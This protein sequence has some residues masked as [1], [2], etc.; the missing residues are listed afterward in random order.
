MLSIS[1]TKSRSYLNELL[2]SLN[3]STNPDSSSSV[4]SDVIDTDSLSSFRSNEETV[5]AVTANSREVFLTMSVF[6]RLV[7]PVVLFFLLFASHSHAGQ[8][9]LMWDPP[10]I[11][12]D[13]TGYVVDYGTAS[14]SYTQGINVGNTTSYTVGNLSDGQTYYFV[15]AAYNS[16]GAESEYSNEV[17]KAMDIAQSPVLT[18]NKTGTG[19]GVVSGNGISCGSICSSSYNTG[20][21]VSLSARADTGSTFTGLSGGGCNGIGICVITMNAA[22]TITAA[23]NTNIV[24]YFIIA[25]V[26]GSG[27]AISPAGTSSV[28]PSGSK[29]FTITPQRG[30]RIAGVTVDSKSVGAVSSYTFTNVAANHTI[31]AAF[32]RS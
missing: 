13:V 6:W 31:S 7:F 15:V 17:S 22:T 26:N 30:Y 32:R 18:I 2:S 28:S 4:E 19:T 14:G 23:F 25:T 21:I 3:N 11:A 8:A 1:G 12:T 16:A 5:G 29:R 20:T 9:A 24:T 27:G 10:E